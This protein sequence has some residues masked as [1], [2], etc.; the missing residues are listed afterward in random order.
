DESSLTGESY[1][2]EKRALKAPPETSRAADA[3]HWLSAGTR[4]LT[5]SATVRIVFT[6]LETLY[7]DIVRS[8]VTRTHART[9]LQLAVSR[10]VAV[11]L[12]A[13][14]A[15]CVALAAILL[16]QGHSAVDAL[17]GALT[18]AVAALPEEFPVVLTFF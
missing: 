10:V 6:G 9:P 2:V 13:A 8:A 7:G 3:S 14:I 4:V 1:P 16:V 15:F 18:L 5:G 11:M 17:V 12:V